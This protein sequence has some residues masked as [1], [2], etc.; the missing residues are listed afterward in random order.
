MQHRSDDECLYWIALRLTPGLGPRRSI[1]LIER[2]HTPQAIFR[3]SF[4]ELVSLGLP[5]AAAR[6]V[7]TGSCFEEASRQHD[8]IKKDGISLLT[9]ED[10]LYPAL[11]RQIFDP[12]PLLFLRGEPALLAQPMVAIVGSRTASVYGT[13]VA[14]TLAAGLAAAGVV[15][16]SG[17]ARGVDTAAHTGA[18]NAAAPTIAVFG[19][20]LDVIYPSENKSL[21]TR[22]AGQGL[23]VSEYPMGSPAYPQNFPVRNRIVSGLSYGVVVVEGNRYSGSSVTARLAL[24]QN[25][26]VF[27]VPGPITST[28]SAGPNLLIQ[29]GAHPVLEVSDILNALPLH[30]S[31]ALPRNS[32]PAPSDSSSQTA[33]PFDPMAHLFSQIID[34]LKVEQ[35]T[36][37]D[38]LIDDLPDFSSSEIIAALFELELEGRVRQLPGKNFAKVWTDGRGG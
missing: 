27:A 13:T 7:S 11:L 32:A 22:I 20:G 35:A 34:K 33:L 21:A 28:L 17:M 25:R 31:R 24:D 23:I 19:C 6:S 1:D 37:L 30:V 16:V 5:A 36:P 26:E 3:A 15:V 2:F 18:L 12:P 10:G 9:I 38:N 29:Q 4:S 14:S 8:I